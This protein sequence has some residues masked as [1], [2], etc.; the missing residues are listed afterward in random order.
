MSSWRQQA[1]VEAPV[2]EVWALVGDPSRYPEVMGDDIVAVT[3]LPSAVEKNATFRQTSNLGFM[4][5]TTTFL[6]EEYEGLREIKLRC[7]S[8][9]YYSHWLLTEAK[10]DTFIDLEIGM[11]PIKLRYR[12][13]D[14]LGGKR[15]WRGMAERALDGVRRVVGRG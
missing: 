14:S 12:A 3:G 8:S 6:V 9:G 5:T 2:E 11:D 10:G 13:F 4:K 15:A 1:T 7:Q